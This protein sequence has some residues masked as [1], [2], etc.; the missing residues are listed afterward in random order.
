M[1][2]GT[3]FR[4]VQDLSCSNAVE[5]MEAELLGRI[6][7]EPFCSTQQKHNGPK[8]TDTECIL[9]NSISFNTLVGAG[10]KMPQ[11]NAVVLQ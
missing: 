11:A 2:Q 1:I 8:H 7:M 10:K 6:G 3:H 5:V 9:L 4:P